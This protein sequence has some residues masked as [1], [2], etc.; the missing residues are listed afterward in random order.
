[1]T[2]CHPLSSATK[3]GLSFQA[4]REPLELYPCSGLEE[5]FGRNRGLPNVD[6]FQLG[7]FLSRV[8][9]H[10]LFACLSR[11]A[12]SREIFA[13]L[14]QQSGKTVRCSFASRSY[15]R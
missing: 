2:E 3:R 10:F 8:C 4:D 11:L 14:G 6:R 9:R 1:R 5:D 12:S 7:L 15:M 13:H